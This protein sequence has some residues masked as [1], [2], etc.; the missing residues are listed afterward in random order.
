MIPA[1]LLNPVEV[2]TVC[3]GT[4]L[5]SFT[6]CGSTERAA[7]KR[8]IADLPNHP[9]GQAPDKYNVKEVMKQTRSS[10]DLQI[11]AQFAQVLPAFSDV[12]SKSESDLGQCDLVQHKIHLY[13]VTKPVK[14][15]NRR[16][17]LH[18][19]RDLRQKI[20]KFLKRKLITPC[21]S[22]YNSPAK[23]GPKKNGKLKLVIDYR[24]LN[25]Q[26]VNSCWPLP[27]VG[28]FFETLEGSFYFSTIDM[29]FGF[30]PAPFRNK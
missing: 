14:L 26:T 20:D 29:S 15:P 12:F 16:W 3:R 7:M 9:Q 10:M 18:M 28:D 19:K 21:R 11:R 13:P 4:S 1:R 25:K 8:V 2:V 27:S 5:G 30:P 17:P 6:V 23:L 22:P 24:Q